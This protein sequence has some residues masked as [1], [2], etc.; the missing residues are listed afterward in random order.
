MLLFGVICDWL[1]SLLLLLLFC[2]EETRT[3][4]Y[5]AICDLIGVVG[6]A[7]IGKRH[8]PQ[9]ILVLL[10]YIWQW[11]SVVIG[12][13]GDAKIGKR[14][15][16]QYILVLLLYIWQWLSVVSLVLLA[17]QKLGRDTH[18]SIYWCCC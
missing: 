8:A 18:H 11:L 2:L 16:P 10:L 13:V 4:V 14:H 6:D 15:A 12:A 17:M 1:L 9:Y 5:L 7:K 3:A